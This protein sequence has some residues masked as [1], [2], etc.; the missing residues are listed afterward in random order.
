LIFGL[1]AGLVAMFLMPGR[2]P[3]GFLVTA[4]L[5]SWVR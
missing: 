1:I 3:R 4:L 5:A 2:D